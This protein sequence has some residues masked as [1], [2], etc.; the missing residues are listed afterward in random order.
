VSSAAPVSRETAGPASRLI[1]RALALGVALA[2]ESAA[3]LLALLDRIALE[4]QNLTAIEGL[5][6]GMER[7]LLDSLAGLALPEIAGAEAAVDIGSGAGF[8]GIALAIA[9]PGLH[10]TLVE[11]ER[12]KA[13][14][15]SRASAAV[16]NLR[17]VADRSEHLA[18]T[19]RERWPLATMRALGP[20][21]VCLELA[22]PLVAVGG[23]VVVWRGDDADPELERAG[24][25]AAAELGLEPAPPV[26]VTPFPGA[27]RRLHAFRRAAPTPR[28]YPRR[29]G[30]AA[31]RPLGGWRA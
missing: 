7:H 26:A 5:E 12:N 2:P 31:K 16:P 20:L 29:A 19:E 18:G 4:P 13:D 9:R 24:A 17:V 11:S 30:R 1:E 23:S 14:W 22:A 6:A 8:P 27:R 3:A 21:P 10:V 15:L 25:E 28:R